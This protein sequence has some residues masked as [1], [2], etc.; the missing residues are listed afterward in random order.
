M[1]RALVCVLFAPLIA[2]GPAFAQAESKKEPPRP[3]EAEARFADGSVVRVLLLV[4]HLDFVTKY[5]KL[6]VP[7][8]QI[9]RIDFGF[10]LP[11]DVAK[12]VEAAVR[13]LGDQSFPEREA[14]VK[15]LVALGAQAYPALQVAARGTDAEAVRRAR[16]ALEQIREKTPADLLGRP[17]YDQVQAAEFPFI[18][19]VAAA[20]VKVKT[21]YFGEV[22]L[23]VTDLRSLR[24]LGGAG[25]AT[26]VVDAGRYGSPP[27]QQW[28]ETDVYVSAGEPLR[29]TASGD[30]DLW[31]MGP[32]AYMARPSG[33]PQGGF[34]PGPGGQRFQP[35]MLLGRVGE[36]GKVFVVGD[37][38]EGKPSEEGKLYLQ[39]VPSPWNNPSAGSYEVKVTTGH[40]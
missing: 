27:G 14:A 35:G 34:V 7:L 17:S 37:R 24:W 19:H 3:N 1:S 38:Y 15:E 40:R 31:P 13:K 8:N 20:S 23:K 39:I 11:E 29:V 18:G 12:K 26:V 28:L 33:Y 16:S 6:T 22:E 25:E 30:V 32:G 2:A 10:R 21:S 9:R 4:D 5:G 36:N